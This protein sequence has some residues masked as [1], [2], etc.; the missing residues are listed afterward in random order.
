MRIG[1]C[2]VVIA[3]LCV[4]L[5]GCG[6]KPEEKNVAEAPKPVAFNLPKGTDVS[7]LLL[8]KLDSGANKEGERVE[9]ML[10]EDIKV[11]DKVVIPKGAIAEA[12]VAW[13]R[14]ASVASQLVNQPARLSIKFKSL[15]TAGGEVVPLVADAEKPTEAYL[16]TSENTVRADIDRLTKIIEQPENKAAFDKLA[17]RFI[18]GDKG[19]TLDDPETS[20][21][22]KR[23]AKELGLS[24]TA[25]VLQKDAKAGAESLTAIADK[26][27]SGKLAALTTSEISL[28]LTA[29]QELGSVADGASRTLRGQ[30][31]GKNIHAPIGTLVKATSVKVAN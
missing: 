13:S 23:V 30:I 1:L 6:P 10:A 22:L 31:K 17:R 4:V 11:G 19:A 14:E 2:P 29:L 21:T 18:D 7:L 3:A 20:E 25:D 15:K 9:M 27:N 5:A 16:F 12:E 26:I 8:K 28:A 24:K